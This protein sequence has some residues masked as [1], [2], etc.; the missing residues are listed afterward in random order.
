MSVINIHG[1]GIKRWQIQS[2]LG[3]P[4]KMLSQNKMNRNKVGNIKQLL[5]TRSQGN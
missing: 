5:M 1:P 4:S 3:L 2:Q